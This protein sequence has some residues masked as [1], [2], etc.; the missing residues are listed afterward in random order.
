VFNPNL[1]K[2]WPLSTALLVLWIL[3]ALIFSSSVSNNNGHLVYA[4]DD[5]YIHMSIA[6][7]FIQQGIWGVT[8]YEFSSSDSS[9]SW[10][11][12]L[13]LTYTVVGVNEITPFI[14]N[15][16]SG[17]LLISV[18]YVHLSEHGLSPSFTFMV[19]FL[20][21]FVSP[22]PSTV[23]IGMEHIFHALITLLFV[24][25]SANM[26]ATD[27]ETSLRYLVMLSLFSI[28]T[29]YE[30]MFLIGVIAILFFIRKQIKASIV[31]IL[32]GVI[33]VVAYGLISIMNGWWFFPTPITLKG[34]FPTFTPIGLFSFVYEFIIDLIN[35]GLILTLIF[36][37]LLLLLFKYNTCETLWNRS[38]VL[39]MIFIPM[40][41]MH[42]LFAKIGNY[43]R[44][45]LY[46]VFLG[47]FIIAV[48]SYEFIT[49]N[50]S[51]RNIKKNGITSTL[52]IL[53]ILSFLSP[54]FPRS[55]RSLKNVSQATSNIYEQQYQ[56]G[57][58][59]EEFYLGD[60]IV[61]NDIGAITFLTRIQLIDING[62]G[63]IEAAN[64][65]MRG[66]WTTQRI[67]NLAQARKARIAVVY[68]HKFERDYRGNDI[69]GVPE[70]WILVGQWQI[71]NNIVCGSDTVSFYAIN[72][73][74]VPE[75]VN[76]LQNFSLKLPKNVLQNG[77]YY[78]TT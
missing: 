4:L 55:F 33:P 63:N 14:L 9:L 74:E 25:Q 48:N 50:V 66:E 47:L 71:S 11:I 28:T 60:T 26:L 49:N 36:T 29:R 8:A 56:M 68:D 12:L 27:G 64:A 7:N 15:L 34:S 53:L 43:F 61:A 21:I 19:L 24:T 23:F 72:P 31:L 57:L 78:D 20:T 70:Q 32:S 65:I 40:T 77:S 16:I 13:A 67:A 62:L 52:I 30:S 69:G 6:K 35:N 37:T 10:I 42:I 45:D 38:L 51:I 54:L 58:F 18:L 5:P 3:V 2:H 76:N 22:L 73:F 1:R 17:T 75:L 44:Y 59:L 39:A 46:I 41:S